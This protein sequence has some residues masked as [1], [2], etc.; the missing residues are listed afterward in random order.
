MALGV[1]LEAEGGVTSRFLKI[2]TALSI[3]A[4]ALG[5]RI[6]STASWDE[7]PDR[8][9]LRR[10]AGHTRLLFGAMDTAIVLLLLGAVERVPARREAWEANTVAYRRFARL[11]FSL[12]IMQ[13]VTARL[14]WLLIICVLRTLRSQLPAVLGEGWAAL[15]FKGRETVDLASCEGGTACLHAHA[16]LCLC[17]IFATVAFHGVLL[18]RWERIGF[19]GSFEAWAAGH[20]GKRADEAQTSAAAGPVGST[21]SKWPVVFASVALI[22]WAPAL[23][24]SSVSSLMLPPYSEVDA[25]TETVFAANKVSEEELTGWLLLGTLV[26]P[27]A[28]AAASLLAEHKHA[29]GWLH[30]LV[31]GVLFAW[32]AHHSVY[33]AGSLWL[34]VPALGLFRAEIG[35]VGLGL[36]CAVMAWAPRRVLQ[37]S[38]AL[39]VAGLLGAA[40][41]RYLTQQPSVVASNASV[42]VYGGVLST[43][44][45]EA[46]E[47]AAWEKQTLWT[48]VTKTG[49]LPYF[50]FGWIA[51]FDVGEDGEA[52]VP[53]W[54]W[55]H[56][57][58]PLLGH[59]SANARVPAG[60]ARRA[61]IQH[62]LLKLIAPLEPLRDAIAKHVGVLASHVVFG[63][64]DSATSS[65]GFPGIQIYLPN[66]LWQV[67]AN[68]HTDKMYSTQYGLSEDPTCVNTTLTTFLVPVVA[69]EGAGLLFWNAS[70]EHEVMYEIGSLYAFDAQLMHSIRP[71]YEWR[72]MLPRM[73]LQAFAMQCGDTW[74]VYH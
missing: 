44:A 7:L 28:L 61:A 48:K 31:S 70:G 60:R 17:L 14:L 22:T 13:E 43:A 49:A 39:L 1:A 64:E 32:V 12:Y 40:P 34:A 41:P 16:M 66:A 24:W 55:R 58:R 65:L 2:G 25:A 42:D 68:P 4:F 26:V 57:L 62:E 21:G 8:L 37:L 27:L 69:P 18:A 59:E 9:L 20:I 47:Q 71:W 51:N 11:S 35:A 29:A 5:L 3:C 72:T 67:V 36:V 74:Y 15:K 52:D 45:C 54:S 38:A 53:L 63:G 73:T 6:I 19:A 10:S 50:S 46:I 30:L 23:T 56:G 33:A